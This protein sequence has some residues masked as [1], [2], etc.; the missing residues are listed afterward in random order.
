MIHFLNDRFVDEKDF[1]ISP[2]DLGLSRGY[3]V[4]DFLRTYQRKPFMLKDHLN[5]FFSSAKKFLLK[6]PYSFQKLEKIINE[7]IKKNKGGELYIKIILTGGES[8]DGITPKGKPTFLIS[9]TPVKPYPLSYFKK[10]VKVISLKNRRFFP[11][12]KSVNYQAAVLAMIEAKKSGAFEA[13]YLDERERVYEGTRSN[14]FLVKKNEVF[15]SKKSI[16]LGVTRQVVIQLI[17]KLKINFKE[18]EIFLDDVREADEVFLTS[19]TVEVLPVFKF[20]DFLI[21]QGK[22]GKITTKIRDLWYNL[23]L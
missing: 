20:D 12:I 22:V 15:T 13:V 2:F 11:D 21:G 10:G 9:F 5:R 3:A 23:Y 18:K 7:G 14:L 6:V 8:D 1:K 19:T 17:K 4:F 16:L